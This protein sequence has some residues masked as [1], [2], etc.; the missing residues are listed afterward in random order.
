MIFL[1][2]YCCK[3]QLALHSA[4]VC[5]GVGAIG[6]DRKLGAAAIAVSGENA[7]CGQVLFTSLQNL[8][9]SLSPQEG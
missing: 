1:G 8:K 4:G 6:F 5:S 3:L 7:H 2:E 9:S